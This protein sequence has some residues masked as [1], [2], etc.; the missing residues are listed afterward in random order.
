MSI[1]LRVQK[2]SA[3]TRGARTLSSSETSINTDSTPEV[4]SESWKP[5]TLRAP[6]LSSLAVF[7]ACLVVVLEYLSRISHRNGGI[8]FA[9]SRFSA[10][11]TFS[12]LYLPTL[13]ATSYS[14]TWSWV[15]LDAKR[16][17]P[18]FQMSRAEGA[19]AKDSLGLDYPFEF[20][21]LVPYRALRRG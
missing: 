17:E 1:P 18:Y 14:I 4:P 10:W 7:T 20:V 6:L 9:A 8:V 16:L 3:R 13:I 11:T 5:I 2:R 15:D 12:F 19:K 21:A